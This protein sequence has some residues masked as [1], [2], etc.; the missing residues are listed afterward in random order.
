MKRILSI[1]LIGSSLLLLSGCNE[2]LE[3]KNTNAVD[4]STF[5]SNAT[6]ATQAVNAIYAGLQRPGL[7]HRSLFFML[8]FSSDE[9]APT[10]N[11]QTPP[12]QL[13]NYAFDATNEHI[14]GFWNDNYVVILRANTALDKIPGVDMDAA[15]KNRLLG[16]ARFLRALANLNLVANF[17]DV[18]LRTIENQG[19]RDL[20]KSPKADV[21]ALIEEDLKFAEANLPKRSEYSA[22]D[23]GRATS[24]AAAGLLAKAQI[25]QQKWAEAEASARRVISSGEYSL[26]SYDRLQNS[27]NNRDENNEESLF[28]VQFTAN[29]SGGGGAWAVDQN[30]GWGGNGEGNFR[31][32]EYGVNGFAFYNAKPSENIVNAFEANDPRIQAFMFGPGSS[33]NGEPYDPIFTASG[34]A[35]AK[36]TD[37]APGAGGALDDGDINIRVL[38]YAD[39]LLLLA[40]ALHKQGKNAEALTF[41]NQVRRRADPGGA[42][43]ADRTD[44]ARTLEYLIHE[45][46]VELCFECQR[47]VDVA[48]WGIGTATF[49]SKFVTGKHEVF[50]IP[51]NE[52]DVNAL[53]TQ[54]A[55]Y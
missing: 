26:V 16:E 34:Y 44:A 36:Y 20:A 39:V 35:I 54:N 8:D 47:R 41:I 22:N 19:E 45:R 55:G 48:R 27:F 4:S 28:E 3:V 11:T 30:T 37:P 17:G 43:L 21:Y 46:R 53:M 50:P 32:K 14:V 1:A 5:Y 10:P 2:F 18:P 52:L 9:I 24:G 42:I 13:L 51:Q 12:T 38:R 15:L 6:E 25:Y 23:L 29:L 40:E 31:P 33:F 49:G 7:Y